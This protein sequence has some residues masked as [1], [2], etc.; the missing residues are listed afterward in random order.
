MLSK[1]GYESMDE[2]I[3]A[4]VPP[5]IRVSTETVNNASIPVLSESQLLARAKALGSENK[6]FKSYIGMGYH[7]AVVPPVILRNVGSRYSRFSACSHT[8]VGH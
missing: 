7:S 5:K 4:T 1:L 8:L 6:P 2:F 3:G